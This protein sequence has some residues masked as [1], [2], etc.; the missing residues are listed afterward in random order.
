M[1]ADWGFFETSHGKGAVDG[2]GGNIKQQVL[3]EEYRGWSAKE[4]LCAHERRRPEKRGWSR[5]LDDEVEAFEESCAKRSRSLEQEKPLDLSLANP[6]NALEIILK[7]FELTSSVKSNQEEEGEEMKKERQEE[8]EQ[9]EGEQKEGEQ[10]EGEQNEGEQKEG[11]QKEGEQKEQEQKEEDQIEEEDDSEEDDSEEESSSEED[12]SDEEDDDSEEDDSTEEDDTE[13]DGEE[14]KEWQELPLNLKKENGDITE[15][16]EL[17]G[18]MNI[19]TTER[20]S[21]N[22]KPWWRVPSIIKT[23][24]ASSD[25]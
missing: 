2:V 24:K 3:M 19:G 12:D 11:E 15:L 16:R 10:K 25:G 5:E 6:G 18:K 4:E 14:E 9:K 21:K 8:E 13:E 20:Q 22:V 23:L 7:S 1:P 17:F